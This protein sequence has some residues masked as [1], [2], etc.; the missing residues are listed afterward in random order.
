MNFKVVEEETGLNLFEADKTVQGED[1]RFFKV[2]QAAYAIGFVSH[3]VF[4]VFFYFFSITEMFLF[5]LFISLPIF[6]LALFLNKQGKIDLAF[7]FA[8]AEIYSHQVLGIY[9]LGWGF[10]FQ[11]ILIYLGILVFFNARW[12]WLAHVT[13]L[14]VLGLTVIFMYLFYYEGQN[15]SF[16]QSFYD[17]VYLITFLLSLIS[18]AILTNHYAK[19]ANRNEQSL[20]AL[21]N[22]RTYFLKRSQRDAISML[23]TAGHFNDSDTG[24]H[25][26]RMAKYAALL[27]EHSGQPRD[28]V[29]LLELAA[30]MHDSGKI[31]IPDYVLKKPGK[32]DAQEWEVMKHHCEMGYQ[33]LSKSDDKLFK[34][35]SEIALY[36]HEQW[37]G[38]GYPNG[39]SG[40]DI[41]ISARLA[42]IADVFDALT[43]QRPYKEPWSVDDALAEIEKGSGKHFDPELV[44]IFLSLK[45]QLLDIKSYWDFKEIHAV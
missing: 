10:G 8:F 31:G 36:H 30:P 5:N 25:I 20:E 4:A 43:M 34:L 2:T 13:I 26:W 3:F 37:D 14:I 24:V 12:N 15:Y 40:T 42:A 35:A 23:G 9:F 29:K 22:E 21:V 41:P 27:A 44:T 6:L 38:S 18:I 19:V 17:S 39:L 16:D 11:I 28:F 32:L 33:I 1:V 45:P 7:V